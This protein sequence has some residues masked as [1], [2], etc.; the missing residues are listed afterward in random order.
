M[1]KNL[2]M[3]TAGHVDH[4][5]TTLIRALTGI[6]CD[7]H[8][9]EKARGI[10]INLGFAHLEL[11][12]DI[13][14][15]I[16]D[17]PGHKDFIKTMVAGV[18]GID[19]VLLVVAADSGIMPQ[20][21]EHFNI[22]R[23]LGIRHGIVALTKSDLAD[24]EMREMAKLEIME[25]L[26]HT[27]LAD[28]PIVEVS[29]TTMQGID[30]LKEEMLRMAQKV[31]EKPVANIFRMYID[32]IFNVKGH[33]IVVT[34]SVLGGKVAVG[35]ELFL[36]PD[37]RDKL[38]IKS[39][40]RHGQAVKETSAGD[41][42]AINVSGLKYDDFERGQ[43]LVD[44]PLDKTMMADA[45]VEYF[46][47]QAQPKTWS[48]VL[49]HTGTFTTYARMHLLAILESE[50]ATQM[51]VQM[52][53]EKPAVLINKDKFVIRNSS[54]DQT[55]GGGTILDVKPLHHRRRTEALKQRM[56][57]LALAAVNE[58]N[59]LQHIFIET[60]KE[61][62]P[63]LLSEIV[64]RTGVTA[65]EVKQLVGDNADRLVLLTSG[66][67]EYLVTAAY[68]KQ[69]T[70]KILR[71]LKTWHQE[72][73]LFEAGLEIVELQG[74]LALRSPAERELLNLM[75]GA[76]IESGVLKNVGKTF[77]LKSHRA[78]MDK[79][80]Q[81]ALEWLR[82]TLKFNRLDRLTLKEL[83][84][85]AHER[86]I[87]KST[88]T[89]LIQFMLSCKELYTDSEDVLDAAIVNSTRMKLLRA[90]AEAPRGLNEK[91]FREMTNAPRK[92]IQMLIEIFM[93]EGVITKETF[94]LHITS[95]GRGV[96]GKE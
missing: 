80:Q 72:N 18:Y 71:I 13:S 31:D 57:Q 26:D 59:K 43:L 90:L 86:N 63:L 92:T 39:I 65:D 58:E 51:V 73:A 37:N 22:M 38:R 85:K 81:E 23:V 78:A 15:G 25:F 75:L 52:H 6:D 14:L 48:Q 53:F 28:A 17:V 60:E 49:F 87:K 29:A 33:G 84:Q 55:L 35:Q 46:E 66:S 74:K 41:R 3:G 7:T 4:G 62:K 30:K 89:Q 70:E 24:E 50:A 12:D 10:T 5:K 79:K 32:R 54:N 83:E 69:L 88:L 36:L 77:A 56:A 9:E 64:H 67:D 20:T 11:S 27:P 16:V 8:K 45:L 91:E 42:A 95:L 21:R 34:G 40:Q 94:Y 93:K 61:G 2:I 1:S 68:Q 76:M 96:L 47:P 19:F 82:D 44:R